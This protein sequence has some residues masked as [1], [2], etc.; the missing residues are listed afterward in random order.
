MGC[1]VLN[2]SKTL[3]TTTALVMLTA[4][5]ASIDVEL[6]DE[7]QAAQS[8]EYILN[9]DA[10]LIKMH[11]AYLASD[12]LLGRETGTEG[13]DMAAQYVADQFKAL[14]LEPAGD[15]GTYFQNITFKRAYRIA[16]AGIVEAETANGTPIPFIANKDFAIGPST[17]LTESSVTAT[18][19]FAGFGIVAPKEGRDDYEGLDVE[20]KIV[21]TLARTPS[22]IQTEERAYYGNLKGKEASDRGAIGTISIPTP[23]SEKVYS[24][25]RL[26]TEGR[27]ASPRMSWLSPDGETFSRAPSIRAGATISPEGAEKL[28]ADAPV[29]LDDIL[30]A[31]EALGGK[32]PTFD[33]PITM[34]ISQKSEID[35]VTS[36]NVAGIIEGSDPALK[37]EV[38]VLTAHLDHIG[39]SRTVEDDKINNGAIDNAA[40]VAT[41][42]EAARMI[43]NNESLR[44]SV[45]FLAVTAEEKGL[46]GSQYF[47]KNPTVPKVNI[48]GNVNLDMPVLTYDFQDLI[49]FGGTRSTFNA[50]I[51]QAAEEMG[52]VVNPDPMPEQG[53]FTRS[54][55]FR[56]VEEG[57]PSVMLSTGFANGGD[58]GWATHFAKHYHRPS[59]DMQNDIN[60]EAAA[61]FAELK[62]RITFTL[63]N[64]DQRP[65]WNKD[66]FFAV[67]FNGPMLEE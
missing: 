22:G 53:I 66:D 9:P 32:T 64:A 65:L 20:G 35:E 29:S 49:V 13:Y 54:D 19:V 61:K 21:A 14:G 2:I 45:M 15:N 26:V 44:R 27:L 43:Q 67:Q 37:D 57:I 60:F 55:H 47:A 12:E 50:A 16:E 7:T 23:T 34:T 3:L 63:A 56:F 58:K 48:V 6:G 62:T 8:G 46:L 36:A 52:L 17:S 4:C 31:A 59:D 11:M 38:I 1:I 28:F 18:V 40:G 39:V 10:D 42:I 5:S 51:S 41:L 33:L 25:R 24:F 30:E